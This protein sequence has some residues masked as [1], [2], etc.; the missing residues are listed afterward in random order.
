[1][2]RDMLIVAAADR[3]ARNRER[4]CFLGRYW[5]SAVEGLTDAAERLGSRRSRRVDPGRRRQGA[6][7]ARQHDGGDA[8]QPRRA[9]GATCAGSE[10]EAQAV[11]G[12]IVEGV[13]AVDEQRAD[14]LREPAGRALARSFGEP[15]RSAAFCGDVL[16]PARDANGRRPC[17][18]S[19]PILASAPR[20][21]GA[22]ASS[23]WRRC[24][25]DSARRVVIASAR[26]GADGLQVQVLR[27]E[28]ELEAVR[29]TR[30]TVLA[31]ISHEFRTPLAA[32]LASIELLQRRHRHDR[33]RRAAASSC[34]RCS[35]ARCG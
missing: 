8:A 23:R 24:A 4:A 35:A 30:D 28:T 26:A 21:L 6:H 18:Y 15:R 13:Y 5:I 7:A 10:T 20:R 11:L 3:R 34:R 33:A 27:D 22:R 9:H 32:Q 12:G 25:D 17:E 29:R 2:T 19:C 1:M 14:P 31:N 16:K